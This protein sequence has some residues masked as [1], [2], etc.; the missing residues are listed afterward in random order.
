MQEIWHNKGLA[1]VGLKMYEDAEDCFQ[2]ANLIQRY[3]VSYMQLGRVLTLQEKFDEALEVYME[4]LEFAPE[5]TDLLT[6]I[7]LLFLRKGD[8][9]QAFEYLG[10]ALTYDAKN[11][12]AILAAGSI[13]QDHRDMDV[14]LSKYRVAMQSTPNSSQLWNNVGMCFFGKKD[15]I[16]AA[17]CLKR[18]LFLSPFEWIVSYNLGLIYL[19]MKQLASAFHYFS[20]AINMKPDFGSSYM[21]LA[22]TLAQLGDFDNAC[23]AYERAIHME[24]DP[25]FRLNYAITLHNHGEEEAA[26]EQFAEFER[27]F[28]QLDEESRHSDPDV[29]RARTLL[30]RVFPGIV[31]HQ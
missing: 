29:L 19:H 24:A 20:A 25:S 13:I 6:T 18:A 2:R 16:T 17:T 10:N 26:K 7:G 3:E 8:T 30:S 5:H 11:P 31:R 23:S 14:A 22:I 12:K 21:F 9:S 4:A 28:A 1:F 27:L 15:L